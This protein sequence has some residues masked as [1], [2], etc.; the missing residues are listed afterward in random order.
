M[1]KKKKEKGIF[2]GVRKPTAPPSQ[3]HNTDKR[4]RKPK[5]KGQENED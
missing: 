4:K 5:H 2:E 3:R 1:A